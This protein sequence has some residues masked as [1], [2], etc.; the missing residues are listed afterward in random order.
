MDIEGML[1]D[2]LRAAISSAL[3]LT[4]HPVHKDTLRFWDELLAYAISRK[5]CAQSTKPKFPRLWANCKP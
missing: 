1:V 4:G 3:R 2:N 5:G